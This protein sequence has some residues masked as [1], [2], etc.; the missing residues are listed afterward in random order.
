M[1]TTDKPGASGST[2]S[3]QPEKTQEP[4]AS[5]QGSQTADAKESPYIWV[6]SNRKDD[7]V[8]LFERQPEHPGG[9]AFVGGPTPAKVGRTAEVERLLHSGEIIQIEEPPD[10]PKKPKEVE[11]V[12]PQNPPAQPGQPI[13]L[14]RELDPELVPLGGPMKRAERQQAQAPREI[15]SRAIVPP[16]PSAETETKTS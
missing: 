7:R 5:A 2:T 16:P 9:E 6:I 13:R 12:A 15:R 8:V 3:G 10:G 14:G 4:G 11:S 1:A